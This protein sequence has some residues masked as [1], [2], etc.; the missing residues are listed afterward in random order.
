MKAAFSFFLLGA[1][2]WAG[3]GAM[4][5]PEADRVLFVDPDSDFS[6]DQVRDSDGQILMFDGKEGTLFFEGVITEGWAVREG[7][8]TGN[9]DFFE[10]R[11]GQEN[12]KQAAFFTEQENA[13]VCNVEVPGGS[14]HITPTDEAVPHN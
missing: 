11:F 12:G 3:C 10:I 1:A 14:L 6:T 7:R 4:P 13:T 8:F 5:P 2:M 9:N